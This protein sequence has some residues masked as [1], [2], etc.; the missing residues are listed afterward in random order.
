MRHRRSSYGRP[1]ESA[2]NKVLKVGT[3]TQPRY[4][5]KI[6]DGGRATRAATRVSAPNWDVERERLGDL[7]TKMTKIKNSASTRSTGTF[8]FLGYLKEVIARDWRSSTWGSCLRGLCVNKTR[9]AIRESSFSKGK[10]RHTTNHRDIYILVCVY[11][12]SRT[13]W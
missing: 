6:P 2:E 3:Y 10:C 4:I 8:S 11:T 5:R 12:Y 7:A 13:C 1:I 9:N